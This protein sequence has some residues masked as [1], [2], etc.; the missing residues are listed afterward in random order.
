MLYSHVALNGTLHL[1]CYDCFISVWYPCTYVLMFTITIAMLVSCI[2]SEKCDFNQWLIIYP[3]YFEMSAAALQINV[4]MAP[5]G[6]S[7]TF[8]P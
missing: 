5:P 1:L 7:L 6:G 4:E 8:L 2:C 3:H